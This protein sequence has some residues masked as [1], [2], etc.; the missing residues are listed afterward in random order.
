MPHCRE[1]A[2]GRGGAGLQV[3]GVVGRGDEGW[4]GGGMVRFGSGR[5][6]RLRLGAPPIRNK[7]HFILWAENGDHHC[8][9]Q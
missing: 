2:G 4:G 3:G 1:A 6:L 8:T 5:G 9:G 7:P